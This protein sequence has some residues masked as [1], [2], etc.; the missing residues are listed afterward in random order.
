MGQTDILLMDQAL[1]SVKEI[2]QLIQ[3]YQP[4]VFAVIANDGNVPFAKLP[5]RF[6]RNGKLKIGVEK[7]WK[8]IQP[9]CLDRQR[10][11]LIKLSQQIPCS[12]VYSHKFVF[13]EADYKIGEFY[14][15]WATNVKYRPGLRYVIDSC[16]SDSLLVAL[17][18]H[19]DECTFVNT[20]TNQ[21]KQT[22]TRV[23]QLGAIRLKLAVEMGGGDTIRR[24]ND[25]RALVLLLKNDFQSGIL[26]CEDHGAEVA[27]LSTLIKAYRSVTDG[28]DLYLVDDGAWN[29]TVLKAL[30]ESII[31]LRE[32]DDASE[33]EC[34][35]YFRYLG[36]VLQMFDGYC[37]D[38]DFIAPKHVPSPAALCRHFDVFEEATIF[39]GQRLHEQIPSWVL[40]FVE[41][42]MPSNAPQVIR[43]HEHDVFAP[44]LR[45]GVDGWER[46]RTLAD[47]VEQ[48][49]TCV[50]DQ[51]PDLNVIERSYPMLFRHGEWSFVPLTRK[52]PD[53]QSIFRLMPP[54]GSVVIF[55]NRAVGLF[56]DVVG[57]KVCVQLY[58]LNIPDCGPLEANAQVAEVVKQQT[59][60][61]SAVYMGPI[62]CDPEDLQ[63]RRHCGNEMTSVAQGDVP[64]GTT[65]IS[66][67]DRA[68]GAVGPFV[69][70]AAGNALFAP[71][72]KQFV[73]P[74]VKFV[75]P[76]QLCVF[77]QFTREELR[78]IAA[79]M[80]P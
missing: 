16:D 51:V 2:E 63:W 4:K 31:H 40:T 69:G 44:I 72:R 3:L 77:N 37:A 20:I 73:G 28:D 65:C 58:F 59:N 41:G 49:R 62:L 43:S 32:D 5:G 76:T 71:S 74:P 57:E 48:Y 30:L 47:V 8:W 42:V 7:D 22:K 54:I 15:N 64:R 78:E 19:E 1:V 34:R 38:A 55:R 10:D 80:K 45:Y 12:I 26:P 66:L 53:F 24:V 39:D 17:G 68:F 35:E 27:A 61:L 13:G 56:R 52:N 67:Y 33:D 25:F 75:P 6:D 79:S 60:K 21:G 29:P 14:R 70:M 36:W 11:K 18:F 50:A 9:S 46:A 23:F